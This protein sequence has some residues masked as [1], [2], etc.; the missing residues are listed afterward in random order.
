MKGA[1]V[2]TVAV[3]SL[4]KELKLK[5]TL[6][7]KAGEVCYRVL[8][9]VH[10]PAVFLVPSN[11]EVSGCII[12]S[13]KQDILNHLTNIAMNFKNPANLDASVAFAKGDYE[14]AFDLNDKYEENIHNHCNFC[15]KSMTDYETNPVFYGCIHGCL[16][17]LQCFMTS[18]ETGEC[19]TCKHPFSFKNYLSKRC[20]VT[21]CGSLK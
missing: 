8:T 21:E 11:P 12:G 13:S 9:P 4:G 3:P 17:H 14:K 16:C 7:H 18:K 6:S 10:H 20:T 5:E 2:L 15:N 1:E 19:P